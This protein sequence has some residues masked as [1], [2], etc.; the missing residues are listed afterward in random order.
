MVSAI[1]RGELDSWMASPFSDDVASQHWPRPYAGST[2]SPPTSFFITG[3]WMLYRQ[4]APIAPQTTI[5]FGITVAFPQ[6]RSYWDD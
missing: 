6:F 2:G 5:N 4:Y 1:G 3:Q